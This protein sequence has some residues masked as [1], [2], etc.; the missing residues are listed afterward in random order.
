MASYLRITIRFLQPFSHSK[1]GGDD[2]E[3]PPSPLRLFGALV[4][5]CAARW[6]ERTALNYSVPALRWLERQPA[7]TIVT[8]LGKRG[9]KYRLYVPDNLG[10]LVAR[11]WSI[12][13]SASIAD[14]RVEKDV[15]P[16]HLNGDAVH[17]LYRLSDTD[18]EFS[19]HR[20]VLFAGARSITHLGWGIDLVVGNADVASED[21]A[22]TLYGERWHPF[23][24]NSSNPLRV[25]KEGTLSD[26]MRRHEALLNRVTRGGLTPGPPLSKFGIVGYRRSGDSLRQSVAAFQILTTDATSMRAFDLARRG[27]TVAGMVRGAAKIAAERSGWPAAKIN[28]FV[29]GHSDSN[30]NGKHIAVGSQRF[31]YLPLPSIEPRGA[32][33]TRVVGNVR[34][35]MLVCPTDGCEDEVAWARRMLSGQELV[36]ED[37]KASVALLSVI[38]STENVVRCYT[39]PAITWATVTPVV[40]PGYDDPEHLRRRMKGGKLVSEQQKRMLERLSDRIEALLRKAIVQAGFSRELADHAQLEWRKAGFWPGTDL[41]DRYGVPSHLKRFPRLHVKVQWRNRNGEP[42]EISGPICF[43]GGRF[44]GIGLFA[45]L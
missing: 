1:R 21:G 9:A 14:Y 18:E 10:D 5:A 8:P 30:V 39:K 44:Y 7:P 41:P 43:G 34:R 33:K 24:G 40:L 20:E 12:G 37:T 6:N 16:V 15:R 36:D 38:P 11:S 17:F 32:G 42:I 26:L 29:L 2:L 35:V 3:W 45:P 28:A 19:D 31:A 22:S 13:G 23:A 27:L 4:S 25:P